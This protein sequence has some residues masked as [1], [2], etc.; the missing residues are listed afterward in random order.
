MKSPLIALSLILCAACSPYENAGGVKVRE[1]IR[2]QRAAEAEAIR[3]AEEEAKAEAE[4]RQEALNL[5][6]KEVDKLMEELDISSGEDAEKLAQ[7][8]KIIFRSQL[9]MDQITV[10]E[11]RKRRDEETKQK[12]AE[13]K[14]DSKTDIKLMDQEARPILRE[15]SLVDN[16]KGSCV[17]Y[18]LSD[19][20]FSAEDIASPD[21]KVSMG[22]RVVVANDRAQ[23]S[24]SCQ[25]FFEKLLGNR[26]Q[27]NYFSYYAGFVAFPQDI[28]SG[29]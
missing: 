16:I 5:R 25:G 3:V 28:S 2:V 4:A 12:E 1:K 9:A 23:L 15:L 18:S 21:I 19:K 13:E 17:L 22:G 8:P 27:E 6:A 11:V 10:A 29:N 20:A 26:F 14:E 24:E 7:F